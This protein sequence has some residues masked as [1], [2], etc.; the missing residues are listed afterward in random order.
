MC[1]GSGNSWC[2]GAGSHGLFLCGGVTG[3]A[4][5]SDPELS[6][7]GSCGFSPPPFTLLLPGLFLPYLHPLSNPHPLPRF[8]TSLLPYLPSP[9][10]LH[11][12]PSPTC[13]LILKSTKASFPSSSPSYFLEG[14][15]TI[16]V[17]ASN[18][19]G[20][21]QVRRNAVGSVAQGVCGLDTSDM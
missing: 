17:F 13:A 14:V 5:R 18:P 20:H 19:T 1:Y 6:L 9:L 2:W 7:T 21:T 11:S 12:C 3:K 10:A 16:L 4:P 15:V 8:P